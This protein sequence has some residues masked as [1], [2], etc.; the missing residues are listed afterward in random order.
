[1]L[2]DLFYPNKYAMRFV[3]NLHDTW[4][5]QVSARVLISHACLSSLVESGIPDL[6]SCANPLVT[7]L[8][9]KNACEKTPRVGRRLS[10][11]DQSIHEHPRPR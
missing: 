7:E 2:R 4:H 6:Y 11:L 3:S 9:G 8:R 5:A 1:M 10:R